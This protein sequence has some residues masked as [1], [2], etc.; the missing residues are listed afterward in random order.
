MSRSSSSNFATT[1]L[2]QSVLTVVI[3]DL[4]AEYELRHVFH[5]HGVDA[6]EAVY[7]FPVPLDSAFMGMTATLAGEQ[8]TANVVSRLKASRSYDEA[9]SDGDSAV[10]LERLEP[11]MLCVN[12]GNL[13]PNEEGE[14]V[15]RFAA[16]L[17]SADGAARFSL[18][19]V[20]RPRYGRSRLRELEE[21]QSDFAAEH[22]LEATIRV[23]GLLANSPVN[24]ATHGARFSREG[25]TQVLHLNQAMLDRDLVLVFDLPVDFAGQARLVRDGEAAI[26]MLS[27]IAPGDLRSSGPCDICLVLDGSGS[28]SGDAIKQSRDALRA[29]A[30]ELG[31]DDRIQILR[32]GSSTVPL[33]RRPLNA[34]ARVREAMVALADTVD[35]DLGGT[36]IGPALDQSID[37]LIGMGPPSGRA[38]AIILVTDGAVQPGEV[39]AIR[40]RATQAG[41]R[42][43]VVAVGSSAG[44]D[45]LAPL[46][47]A[48]RAVLERAVPAEP[49]DECVMRQLRR[50]RDIGPLSIDVEWGC[51]GAKPLRMDVAYPGDAVSAV[52]M[53]TNALGFN[54]QVR[55][56]DSPDVAT[57]D[58]PALQ[59]APALRAIAGH[60]AWQ[61]AR[62]DTKESLALRYGLVTN[63]TSAVLIRERREGDKV[64]G[65]PTIVPVT[66]MAPEGM[67]LRSASCSYGPVDAFRS[68]A[69][70]MTR[71]SVAYKVVSH[72]VDE[73]TGRPIVPTGYKPSPEE[74]Y[75]NPLQL[76]YFRHRLLQ[77]RE[78]LCEELR[79]SAQ[80]PQED[81][82]DEDD[83]LT[84]AEWRRSRLLRARRRYIRLIREIDN[85]IKEIDKHDYGYCCDT[86]EEIGLE[87]LEARLTAKR[88]V[89]AQERWEGDAEARRKRPRI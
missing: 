75:M 40:V 85:A 26:G 5:N 61:Q 16:Q 58:P 87:R 66:H 30:G 19:M 4:V 20:H 60:M 55:I 71:P 22:L 78:Q 27:L 88:S 28:M 89:V 38:Q 39:E 23:E 50:T 8:R 59:E 47:S 2:A 63:H 84:D 12:L 7:S 74:E 82:A 45:V 31:D 62:D 70:P 79:G 42:I 15:L 57:F 41:L 72:A 53:L 25:G 65:L 44:A 73:S 21:P 9:I 24:C 1:P 80:V 68:F 69:K 67:A 54:A 35:A 83:A 52:A 56:G 34:S 64:D 76:E 33:F 43:F 36:D 49:I 10:L 13:K 14:V 48:T 46:A 3:T 17:R 11:G 6:I 29:V 86:G 77:W 37:A 51:Q 81:A 32:F 18:P